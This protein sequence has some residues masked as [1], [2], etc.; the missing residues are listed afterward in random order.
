M[1]FNKYAKLLLALCLSLI[2][3]FAFTACSEDD[4][5]P[6]VSESKPSTWIRDAYAY[7]EASETC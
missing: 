1:S 6:V 2:I 7:L 4:T 5:T 3:V